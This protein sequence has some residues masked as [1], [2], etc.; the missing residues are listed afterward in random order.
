MSDRIS[1]NKD[2]K[3]YII[4]K[5]ENLKKLLKSDQLDNPE[6]IKQL[7]IEASKIEETMQRKQL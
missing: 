4:R 6:K 7:T 1:I 2:E 5:R 3:S